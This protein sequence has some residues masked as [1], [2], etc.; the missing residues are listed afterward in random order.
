MIDALLKAEM[1]EKVQE[2]T[3]DFLFKAFLVPKP[4]DPT[5]PPRMVIY[6]SPLKYCFNRNPFKQTD[7]FTILSTLKAGCHYHFVADMSTGYWQIRL[8][9]SPNGSYITSLL[10]ERG[11]F[12][13]KVMPMGIQP[14]SNVLS[15]QMQEVFGDLFTTEKISEGSPMVWDLDNFLGGAETE[16]SWAML[17]RSSSICATPGVFT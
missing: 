5:G 17:W 8:I 15:H 13:W 6:Y 12:R 16:E 9:D 7:P 4:R 1:I 10:C 3:G 14:A 2:D 11:I